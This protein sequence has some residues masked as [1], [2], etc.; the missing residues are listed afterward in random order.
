MEVN[1]PTSYSVELNWNSFCRQHTDTEIIIKN[2]F[3]SWQMQY[4][5]KKK[6]HVARCDDP[7]TFH[8]PAFMPSLT[9]I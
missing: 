5:N 1:G 9:K 6:S 8:L 3:L 7:K 2:A 4:M